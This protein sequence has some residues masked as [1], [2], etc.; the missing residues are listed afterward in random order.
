M[1]YFQITFRHKVDAANEFEHALVTLM[2]MLVVYRAPTTGLR[3]RGI[4]YRQPAINNK[5][6]P[7]PIPKSN[8]NPT[9]NPTRTLTLT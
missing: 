9:T 5:L 7:K 3:S 2:K 4:V 1:I 6:A 8:R